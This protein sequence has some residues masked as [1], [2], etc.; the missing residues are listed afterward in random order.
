MMQRSHDAAGEVGARGTAMPQPERAGASRAT[1]AGRGRIPPS[2]RM[3]RADVPLELLQIDDPPRYRCPGESRPIT[4]AAHLARLA[5]GYAAC[6]QCPHHEDAGLLPTRLLAKVA[7]PRASNNDRGIFHDTEVRG[8]Y[9]NEIDRRTARRVA[10]R[11]A[12]W[13]WED[14]PLQ[15]RSAGHRPLSARRPVVVVGHDHRASSLDLLMGTV[16]GLTRMSCRVLELG[17]TTR[18]EFLFGAQHFGADAGVYLGG[19]DAAPR[20]VSMFLAGPRGLPLDCAGLR[21]LAA[22]WDEPVC[23]PL[24]VGGERERQS[25]RSVYLAALGKHFH[26]LRP[27]RI[28][29]GTSG[30]LIGPLLRAVFADR[31]CE[32]IVRTLPR[33][34]PSVCSL[35]APELKAVAAAV[36]R[37]RAHLG[38]FLEEDGERAAFVDDRGELVAPHELALYATDVAATGN[39]SVRIAAPEQAVGAVRTLGG[40]PAESLVGLGDGTAAALLRAVDRGEATFGFD[41]LGRFAFLD[42][43]PRID[44]IV[45]LAHVLRRLSLTDRPFSELRRAQESAAAA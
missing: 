3:V 8:T 12:A 29:V 20:T 38:L 26:A 34:S 23:R 9:L 2:L 41:G 31:P 42:P 39:R 1:T 18:A 17:R 7:V 19:T 35:D 21:R 5:A 25:V 24:R 44:A 4:R 33:Q 45:Q 32:L 14:R 37:H 16:E 27:L 36:R 30:P 10:E 28:V 43:L 22:M 6:R 13:L 11:F 15:W 40:L